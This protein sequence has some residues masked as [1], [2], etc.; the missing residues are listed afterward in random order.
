MCAVQLNDI[1]YA[2]QAGHRIRLA[3]STS[4][5]PTVWPSP[6]PVTLRLW[7]GAST[8]EL[9][10]R[11][12]APEDERLRPFEPP[13]AAQTARHKPLRELPLRRTIEIDL[14]TNETVYTFRAASSARRWRASRR[15]RW[16]SATLFLEAPS[17][18][19]VRP[20]IRSD[21]GRPAHDDA[22]QGL[23]GPGSKSR[24]RLGATRDAFQFSADLKAFEDDEPFGQ[25]SWQLSIPRQLV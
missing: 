23:V 24:A 2:F 16:T 1:A 15:S 12:P 5:W 10:V 19:R 22:A 11:P 14:A 8:I 6:E 20:A 13:S 7:T 18:L 3:L 21:R 25:R 17:D 9:P 4:Y